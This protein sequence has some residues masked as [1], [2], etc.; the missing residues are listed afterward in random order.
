MI[1]TVKCDLNTNLLLFTW[2]DLMIKLMIAEL[3]KK[4]IFPWFLSICV[5]SLPFLLLHQF[6]FLGTTVF[7]ILH[8]E[9][10]SSDLHKNLLQWSHS[11]WTEVSWW[12][13][14]NVSLN[15]F[16]STFTRRGK[17]H[18][19]QEENNSWSGRLFW[20]ILPYQNNSATFRYRVQTE[21]LHLSMLRVSQ[22]VTIYKTEILF[23][24]FYYSGWQKQCYCSQ[25]VICLQVEFWEKK[26]NFFLTKNCSNVCDKFWGENE[27]F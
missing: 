19:Q 13:L 22:K 2:M 5:K 6:L 7:S 9:G 8:Q 11:S 26:E 14:L 23:I 24:H 16:F 25:K 18:T 27:N 1:I 12:L 4:S 20:W 3:K 15:E 21:N 17:D 10:Q